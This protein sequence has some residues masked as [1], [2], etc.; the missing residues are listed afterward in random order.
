MPLS[1][2]ERALIEAKGATARHA[3]SAHLWK[4]AVRMT[5][6]EL[7]RELRRHQAP[8]CKPLPLFESVTP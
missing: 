1:D 6:K 8:S 7:E 2:A 3:K 5:A 4:R